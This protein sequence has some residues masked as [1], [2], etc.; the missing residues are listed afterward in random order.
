M[1][2]KNFWYVSVIVNAAFCG[3]GR[4]GRCRCTAETLDTLTDSTASEQA[5]R[6]VLR[7]SLYQSPNLRVGIVLRRPKHL[8]GASLVNPE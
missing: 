3:K 7:D 6:N 4:H 5:L 8:N 2:Y 1:H